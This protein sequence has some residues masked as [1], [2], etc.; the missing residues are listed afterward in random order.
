MCI[1]AFQKYRNIAA[2][3]P[4][5]IIDQAQLQLYAHVYNAPWQFHSSTRHISLINIMHSVFTRDSSSTSFTALDLSQSSKILENM[6]YIYNA[7]TN[8]NPNNA[9]GIDRISPK[10][11][12]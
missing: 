10:V 4:V 6:T 11:W 7:L 3:K 8:L 9:Q 5:L 12:K 1:T 2:I